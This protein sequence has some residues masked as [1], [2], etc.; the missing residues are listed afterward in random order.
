MTVLLLAIPILRCFGQGH[1]RIQPGVYFR[2]TDKN[3]EQLV[4]VKD[5]A[6]PAILPFGKLSA[7]DRFCAQRS[8]PSSYHKSARGR[9]RNQ[10]LC[11]PPSR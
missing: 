8:S 11:E 7:N 2:V 9:G 4:V 10:T 5:A 3:V 6:P 1:Q